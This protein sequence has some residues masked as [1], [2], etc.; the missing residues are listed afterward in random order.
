MFIS[1]PA[2]TVLYCY[3][4][5]LNK[6]TVHEVHGLGKV[7]LSGRQLSIGSGD[8]LK[9]PYTKILHCRIRLAEE[10][11]RPKWQSTCFL[12][13]LSCNWAWMP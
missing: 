9:N 6:S 1:H 3:L 2:N 8:P 11:T 7:T 12:Y 10:G 13:P 4:I 5:T